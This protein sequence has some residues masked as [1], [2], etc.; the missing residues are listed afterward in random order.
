MGGA[1]PAPQQGISFEPFL[2]TDLAMYASN[3]LKESMGSYKT[4]KSRNRSGINV[5]KRTR[6]RKISAPEVADN[7]IVEKEKV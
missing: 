1:P 7:A 5:V 3:R 6:T 4:R 2:S